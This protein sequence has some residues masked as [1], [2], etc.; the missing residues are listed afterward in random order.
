MYR[1]E[2]KYIINSGTAHIISKRMEQIC[3]YDKNADHRGFY[4]V[5]SLYFD[6]FSNSAL[7]DNVIGQIA[8]KKYRIRIYDGRDDFI[9]LEK[10]TKHNKVGVKEAVVITRKQYDNIIKGEYE[11][12]KEADSTLLRG[13]Y[14]EAM[15]RRLRPKVIV[16]YNRQVFAYDYGTVR[17][18]LDY[19]VKYA[20]NSI[21]LFKKDQIYAPAIRKDQIIMEVKYTGFLPGHIRDMIQQSFS[22]QQSVSKYT[23]CRA[24]GI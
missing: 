22:N 4:R 12:F 11:S 17:I 10:K 5:S 8:R 3:S 15:S 6:D 24:S 19:S 16:D 9:R 7:N 18:T 13:F 14:M 2:L 20:V 21:D 1:N 23:L